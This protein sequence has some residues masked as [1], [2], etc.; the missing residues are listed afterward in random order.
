M[1]TSAHK[2]RLCFASSMPQIMT[3]A[4]AIGWSASA[5]AQATVNDP[6]ITVT[7]IVSGLN[8]PISM[9]FL[10]PND[11]FVCEKA[12]GQVKHV[13]NGTVVGTVL[14]LAVNS[15]SERGLLF[16]TLHPLFPIVPSVY[17]YSTE[18]S[19][20]VDSPNLA[21]V[22]LMS[23]R[24]D[25][26]IWN[27]STLTFANNLLTLR[28]YQA[29][30]NQPLRG[31][32][33]G[34]VIRFGPD[35]K[36]YI[37]IG[38][39][40]RRGYLQNNKQGPNPDDQFGGPFPDDAH[41]T[42]VIYRLNEDGTT[43]TDNPFFSLHYSP[44]VD[45][46]YMYGLRNSFGMAFDPITGNLWT[47]ENGDDS[48]DEMNRVEPGMNG[49][50]VQICGP[51]KRV[52]QFHDI[53]TTLPGRLQQLRWPP[54]RI[55]TDPNLALRRLFVLPGSHYKDPEFSWK[56][57][58]A[59]GGINFVN[60]GALGPEWTQTM[61]VGAARTNLA[62][63][64]LFRFNFTKDRK[65]YVFTDS[66]LDDLVADNGF[67][68]DITESESLKVG[69]GFGIVPDIET[70]PTGTVVLCSLDQGVIYE[71]KHN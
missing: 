58:V 7:P 71:L 21:D 43:P 22:N 49:G 13:V 20:G 61:L 53:E 67:K 34:G 50:W 16:I 9:A 69:Q 39:Q 65:H 25:R 26:F 2:L 42:G 40:G 36:L 38:D 28:S 48:F 15:A 10:G 11:F 44:R 12:T 41:T 18:S 45:K 6:N 63:G 57:A 14:D 56:Y 47:Q 60:T 4:L 8:Q 59:Q 5:F 23:N 54:E 24:V 3:I 19:T 51:V 32:H 62:G 68:F 46:I 35:G 33:N 64:Y 30:A 70:S 52:Q 37:V 66:R 27:G 1:R 31:N 29:D 17:I 55:A